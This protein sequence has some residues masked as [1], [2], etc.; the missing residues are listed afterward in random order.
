MSLPPRRDI[1]ARVAVGVTL[2]AL[3][4]WAIVRYAW[5]AEDA[6]ITLRTVD[7]FVHGDGLRWNVA[8]RVQAYTHPLWLFVVSAIYAVTR[9]DFLTLVFTGVAVSVAAFALVQRLAASTVQAIACGSV[10]LLSPAFVDFSTSG[11]ENPLSHLLLALFALV[12]VVREVALRTLVF[13]AALCMTNRLDLGLLVAPAVVF[14]VARSPLDRRA[15]LAHVAVGLTP[16]IAW[17]LFALVY[18]GAP[19]P[20]TAYAKLATGVSFADSLRHG[21]GYFASHATG[22]PFTLV[23]IAVGVGLGATARDAKLRLLAAGVALYLAYVLRIGGDFMLGRFLT[24]PLVVAAIVIGRAPALAARA[25]VAIPVTAALVLIGAL[26]PRVPLRA[27]LQPKP[28]VD[29]HGVVDERLIYAAHSSLAARHA[30]APMPDHHWAELGR[31]LRAGGRSM[32][33]VRANVGFLGYFAGP[34]VHLIDENALTD[35]LL[36]RLPIAPGDW[37]IGHFTRR[38]PDGYVETVESGRNQLRDPSLA[39]LYDSLALVTRAPLFSSARF[40]AILKLN[41]ASSATAAPTS[42]KQAGSIETR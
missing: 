29:A 7:N 22:D 34:R 40:A 4:A 28:A 11:L 19:F 39:R 38:L 2:T 21:L 6:Y 42:T 36:A 26:A 8:E 37:R 1:A 25:V 9:E 24:P 18:Y 10:L 15:R 27:P 41:L 17:E 31:G 14:A 33:L 16:L 23:A 13:V 32:V 12:F 3:S 35:P 5:V 20:N 30:G